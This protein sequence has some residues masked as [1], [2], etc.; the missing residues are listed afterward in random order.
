MD[1]RTV[2]LVT[3]AVTWLCLLAPTPQ[4]SE[5]VSRDDPKYKFAVF[6]VV[7][8][9]KLEGAPMRTRYRVSD[10]A[11]ASQCV[12]EPSCSSV[13]YRRVDGSCDLMPT[14]KY[15]A[16]LKWVSGFEHLFIK[17]ACDSSPCR[18]G[19]C[20]PLINNGSYRCTCIKQFYGRDCDKCNG[21]ALGM[22]D[23]R[24]VSAQLSQS[25][26]YRDDPEYGTDRGRLNLDI[27]PMGAH[28]RSDDVDGGWFKIDLITT[29]IITAFAMQGYGRP[30][31][32]DRVET[33]QIC[34]SDNNNDWVFLEKSPGAPKIFPGNNNN[35]DTVTTTFSPPL[36]A[37]YFR[38]VAKTCGRAC[39]LRMEIYGCEK[40]LNQL[41]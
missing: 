35:K 17:S 22:E 34:T 29:K 36:M 13:N 23:G 11:C 12:G 25:S 41:S 20:H 33:F 15:N 16:T 28:L 18:Y 6:D 5:F 32:I 1:A 26:F 2:A 8:D 38:I 39:A 30:I 7:N 40:L 14:T 4:A 10:I 37:R 9:H 27:W 3:S 21:T 31:S 24:I 19:N